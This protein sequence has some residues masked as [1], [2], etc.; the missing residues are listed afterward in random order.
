MGIT[1]CAKFSVSKKV[2]IRNPTNCSL[3]TNEFHFDFTF[4]F[5]AQ[6]LNFKH[7]NKIHRKEILRPSSKFCYCYR[8]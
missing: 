6:S 7:T 3:P 4:Q 2:R 8:N 5:N 1:N